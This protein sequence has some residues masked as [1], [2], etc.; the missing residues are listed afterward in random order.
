[1]N[2]EPLLSARLSA[3]E[4]ANYSLINCETVS[5]CNSVRGYL[6]G[7]IEIFMKIF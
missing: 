3:V 4:Q 1:M 6:E 5:G 2:V 7:Q